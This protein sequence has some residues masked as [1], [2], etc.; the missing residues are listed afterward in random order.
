[1]SRDERLYL[2]DMAIHIAKAMRYA[3]GMAYEE[4]ANN[5]QVYDAILHNLFVIGEAANHLPKSLQQRYANVSW[6]KMIGLRNIIAH[7]YHGLDS[8]VLWDVIHSDLPSLATQIEQII[9]DCG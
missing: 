7:G 5:E 9:V 3:E 4:F 6:R 2:D 8:H 1:M